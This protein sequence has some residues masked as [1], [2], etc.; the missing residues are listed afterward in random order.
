MDLKFCLLSAGRHLL[1][2]H[3]CPKVTVSRLIVCDDGGDRDRVKTPVTQSSAKV[4]ISRLITVMTGVI[5][6]AQKRR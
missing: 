3:A 4:I 1:A 6:I 5:A 2:R